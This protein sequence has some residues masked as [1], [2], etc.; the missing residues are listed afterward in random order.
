MLESALYLFFFTAFAAFMANR[1]YFGLRRKMIKVK[2]VTYSRRGEPMM[3]IAV[4][5]MA[6][7]GLIFGFGM[8]IV[9]VAANL[10]Y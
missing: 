4:I 3:Y 7:W 1:L 2:G 10:G 6:G 8:C 5:A 9:V